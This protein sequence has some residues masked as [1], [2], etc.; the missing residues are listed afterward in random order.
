MFANRSHAA[1]FLIGLA[2]FWCAGL[3]M[4]VVQV[5][6]D[7]NSGRHADAGTGEVA[8]ILLASV[9]AILLIVAQLFNDRRVGG[10]RTVAGSYRMIL[11]ST[12]ADAARTL[13]LNGPVTAGLLYAVLVAAIVVFVTALVLR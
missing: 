5:T 4:S 3:L 13:G 1:A 11:P 6:K 2:A 8:A 9:G 7:S 10:G 12:L